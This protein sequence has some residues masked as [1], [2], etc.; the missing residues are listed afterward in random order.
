MR[1]HVAVPGDKSISHRSVLFGAT[2][3]LTEHPVD[4]RIV[5]VDRA[6]ETREVRVRNAVHLRRHERGENVA[7]PVGPLEV[8]DHQVRQVAVIELAG[9]PL[10][11]RHLAHHEV[12]EFSATRT[13]PELR[14][15]N[16]ALTR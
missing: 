12:I 16:E 7:D 10:L 15:L 2:H 6:L 1:G 14:S 9:D 13:G 8:Q 3:P 11:L 4:E 5:L